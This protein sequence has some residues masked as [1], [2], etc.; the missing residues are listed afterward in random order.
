M[1]FISNQTLEQLLIEVAN[2]KRL[3]APVEEDGVLLYKLVN[4]IEEIVWDFQKPVKSIK[5]IYFP[6]TEHLMVFQ[7]NNGDVSLK[8]SFSAQPS[9]VF[10][11]RSC[12]ARGAL[13]LDQVLIE[14][15]PEERY[16]Q[17]RR[18]NTILIGL[19]CQRLGDMC[20][21]TSV[22]GDPA[23]SSGMD[24]MLHSIDGGYLVEVVSAAG[25][26]LLAGI[27]LEE[28]DQKHEV[29]EQPA[30]YQIPE[31]DLW[32]RSFHA[33]LWSEAAD[34]CLSCRICAYVCPTCR[35]FDVRDESIS[36]QDGTE[37]S[38]RIRCWDSCSGEVYRR[39]AGGHN[40]REAKADRLR[41]RIYCKLYYIK[42]QS[43]LLACTG[44]GRCIESCPVN[45]DITEIMGK[46]LEGEPV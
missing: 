4:Q 3:F 17:A 8:E 20:F 21:C 11:V 43:G 23:D 33:A 13:V 2:N 26:N 1:K 7:K 40:P 34:R 41:N 46:L 38:E 39:I 44:C 31:Q 37:F 36:S 32:K 18:Q 5:E 14:S 30:Q 10:G 12:D 9:V 35:C 22:G 6:Q 45:V 27:H 28:V 25:E 15:K 24:L 16:Y 19:A 29:L 42:E